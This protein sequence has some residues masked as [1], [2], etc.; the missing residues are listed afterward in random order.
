MTPDPAAVLVDRRGG[1]LLLQL[2]R[3]ERRNALATPVLLAV[4]DALRDA[5]SNE[6]V[7]AVVLT[8]G[9]AIFA[10]GADIGELEVSRSD[11]PVE[12]PRYLAWQEIRAF[13]K[14]LIAAVEGWCLGAG[15]ELMMCCDI[16]VAAKGA[17]IGQPETNLG[18][19]PGAGGTA[20]LP[21][22]IGRPAAMDMVLTGEPIS[23]Q[24]A[25]DL[26]LVSR[27]TE[28]GSAIAEALELATKIATRAPQALAQ[29]KASVRAALDTPFSTHIREER[30]RFIS[31]LGG[32]EIREGISAFREKRSPVWR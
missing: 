17:R 27:V 19:I 25:Y 23:A 30:Q 10:A 3:P 11:D 13:P 15:A 1:V 4:A 7:R 2:S 5:D 9:S 28:T 8:G 29:A 22:L 12:S 21:R 6:T 32:C 26:G 14:P 24:R 16:V 18:I 31:L 20:L